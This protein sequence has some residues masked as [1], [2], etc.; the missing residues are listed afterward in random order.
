MTCY[1]DEYSLLPEMAYLRT[2]TRTPDQLLLL[3]DWQTDR[4]ADWLI[5]VRAYSRIL[6]GVFSRRLTAGEYGVFVL[7]GGKTRVAGPLK[8]KVLPRLCGSAL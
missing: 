7:S 5:G 2:Y 1:Y 8:I 6:R 3:A 4:L